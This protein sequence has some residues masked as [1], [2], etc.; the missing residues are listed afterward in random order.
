MT[1]HIYDCVTISQVK[2]NRIGFFLEFSAPLGVSD[3]VLIPGYDR[4]A[5][6]LI[7]SQHCETI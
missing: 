6:Y 3:T 5:P 7:L 4:L 1:Q 2:N